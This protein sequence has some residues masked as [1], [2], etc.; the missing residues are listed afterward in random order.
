VAV[1]D[2]R[3]REDGLVRVPD[4]ERDARADEG[5]AEVGHDARAFGVDEAEALPPLVGDGRRLP[6]LHPEGDREVLTRG[7]RQ[8]Q[9][10]RPVEPEH[11]LARRVLRVPG[12]GGRPVPPRGR[13]V[14][15][16]RIGR[17]EAVV[18]GEAR[19]FGGERVRVAQVVREGALD[20]RLPGAGDGLRR[21]EQGDDVGAAAEA[22]VL[23]AHLAEAGEDPVDLAVA[24]GLA[25]QPRRALFEGREAGGVRRIGRPLPGRLAAK[26]DFRGIDALREGL[27]EVGEGIGRVDD[28]RRGRPGRGR[29]ARRRTGGGFRVGAARR[30]RLPG[31]GEHQEDDQAD[32]GQDDAGD[33]RRGAGGLR[34]RP[35]GGG[36]RCDGDAVRGVAGPGRGAPE[37]RRGR[38]GL[39]GQRL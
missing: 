6:R 24:L 5:D 34:M 31:E 21:L 13:G 1:D 36:Q 9:L 2:L 30:G 25:L 11:A 20:L 27:L 14:P 12:G 4:A 38:R 10:G 35:R 7:Q 16:E 26:Q 15:G 18:G 33:E 19:G 23:V 28:D 17:V 32:A 37:A 3:L 39:L 22:P 8:D 29:R